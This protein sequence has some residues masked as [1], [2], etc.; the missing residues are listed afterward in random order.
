MDSSPQI[1]VTAANRHQPQTL[2]HVT[3]IG[4]NGN[5][6]TSVTP[7]HA[8]L[9]QNPSIPQSQHAATRESKKTRVPPNS[10]YMTTIRDTTVYYEH[11]LAAKQTRSPPGKDYGARLPWQPGGRDTSDPET[12]LNTEHNSRQRCTAIRPHTIA[13]QEEPHTD[14]DVNLIP[15]RGKELNEVVTTKIKHEEPPPKFNGFCMY[16]K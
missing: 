3:S 8:N 9:K 13:N 11:S 14:R 16:N 2:K 5:E 10:K 6:N 12:K 4:D 1:G 7:G 15:N